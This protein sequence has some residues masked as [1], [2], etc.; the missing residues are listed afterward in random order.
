MAEKKTTIRDVAA[1]AGVSVTTVSDAMSGKGRLPEVTRLKIQAVAEELN[2]RPSAIAR[3]LR[4]TG[5]G[6]VGI[7]VA[8]AGGGGVLTDVGYWASI[9]IHAS[10]AIL[11]KGLAPV[12]LPHDVGMLGKLKIP[13]D[14]ALVIDPLEQDLVLAYFEKKKVHCVT[15]GRDPG[16]Q[17][18]PWVDDDNTTG[19]RQLLDQAVPRGARLAYIS[20]GPTKSYAVDSLTGARLWAAENDAIVETYHCADLEPFAV[21]AVARKA[22]EAGSTAILA[23]NDRLALRVLTALKALGRRVPQDIRL[24]SGSDAQELELASPAI[25]AVIQHPARLAELAAHALMDLTLGRSVQD[26]ALVPMGIALRTSAPK[27]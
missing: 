6:L 8:P 15:V 22:L 19:V 3:G 13:L 16:H 24:L 18:S 9:V 12:L 23:Q 5:L 2:Y 17:G 11:D 14:G 20:V 25:S 26:S 7:C 10:Q 4:G 1:S 21:G 27:I